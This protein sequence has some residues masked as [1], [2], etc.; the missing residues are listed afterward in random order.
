MDLR[1]VKTKKAIQS[2]FLELRK[3]TPLEKI[4]VRDLCHIA[5][6]NKS[7]FYNHYEDAFALSEEMENELLDKCM[8]DFEY[9]DC[10][11]TEPKKFLENVPAVLEKQEPFLSVLFDGRQDVLYK[12]IQRQFRKRYT[13]PEMTAEE[14]VKLTFII[15][16]TIYSMQELMEDGKYTKQEITEYTAKVIESI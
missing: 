14:E 10:L 1:I 12:K 4:R 2:A 6:I 11:L 16:G 7:T 8:E 9:K 15:G 5:L 13:N 3:T